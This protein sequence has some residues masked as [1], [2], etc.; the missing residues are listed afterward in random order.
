VRRPLAPSLLLALAA[1]GCISAPSPLTP[2]YSGTVGA[3]GSGVQTDG[4]ELPVSGPGFVR[5]RPH[6]ANH[7]GRPRLV[8]ALTRIAAELS[9]DSHHAPPL[10]IG[11]LSARYGGK[12]DG[13]QSHRT[14]RDVDILFHFV[15][16][17]GARVT[18]PGF[19][20]VGNDGL[21]RVH[22]T[23]DVLRFDVEQQWKVVRALVD[24]PEIG[25]QFMFVSRT[26]EALLVEYALARGEP[27]ERVLRA[28]SV[29]L[30]PGDSLSHDDHVHL[31]IACSREEM[32]EGCVGGGPYWEWL[33]PLPPATPFDEPA[34][35]AA[36]ASEDAPPPSGG[37]TDTL[38]LTAGEAAP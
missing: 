16:P 23:G 32:A 30:E 19:V 2:G 27:L 26:I 21:A 35:L 17:A 14:G 9:T 12:I 15:T 8:A 3:P 38:G 13:H 37:A 25:V 36:L 7:F 6:G 10:V 11:D 34:L 28:Q 18:A 22:D 24:A 5:F 29:M 4:V 1:T 31:R 20:H 33:P